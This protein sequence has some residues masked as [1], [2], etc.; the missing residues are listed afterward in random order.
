MGY[1]ELRSCLLVDGVANLPGLCMLLFGGG[2]YVFSRRVD[3]GWG[4]VGDD[5]HCAL[6][7]ACIMIGLLWMLPVL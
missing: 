6:R 7:A 3:G 4:F 1:P 5:A 2:N